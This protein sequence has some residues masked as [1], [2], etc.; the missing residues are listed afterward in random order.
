[1]IS[2]TYYFN[3]NASCSVDDI[4]K[5]DLSEFMILSNEFETISFTFYITDVVR[6]KDE[7]F[8]IFYFQ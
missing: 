5:I 6:Q 7:M 2:I 3:P 4:S 1:M 8:K